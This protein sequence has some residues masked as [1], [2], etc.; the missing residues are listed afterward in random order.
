M[1]KCPWSSVVNDVTSPLFFSTAKVALASGI[2]AG[3][4]ALIGPGL[5][6]PIVITPSIPDSPA[7]GVC[8]VEA[9]TAMMMSPKAVGKLRNLTAH[10]IRRAWR[11]STIPNR[12]RILTGLALD[13]GIVASKFSASL[14]HETL[15][16]VC[17]RG[18]CR[19]GHVWERVDALSC[20]AFATPVYSPR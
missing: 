11:W 13:E 1:R 5:A 18:W 10:Y 3:A 8:P 6:G 9:Q 19:I 17:N 4:S 15:S 20:K 14:A 16:A 2:E 12:K 7:E